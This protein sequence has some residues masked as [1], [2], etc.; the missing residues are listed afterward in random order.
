MRVYSNAILGTVFAGFLSCKAGGDFAGGG[1]KKEKEAAVVPQNKTEEFTIGPAG[2]GKVD[3]AFFLDTSDSM[4]EE[5]SA[6]LAGLQKFADDLA[7][8]DNGLDYQMFIVA[9]AAKISANLRDTAKLDLRNSEVN[10]HSALWNAY[11]FLEGNSD[12]V[13]S[14]S[15][16]LRMEAVKELVFLTDDDAEGITAENLAPYLKGNM[17]KFGQTRI[18]GFVGLPTSARSSTCKI[19]AVGKSY[20]ALGSDPA[21]G[22][23]VADVCNSNWEGL[24]SDLANQVR[25]RSGRNSEFYLKGKPSA[26]IAVRLDGVSFSE[27]TYDPI[28]NKVTLDSLKISA[29]SHKVEVSY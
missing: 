4:K 3:L 15:L 29:G 26:G 7:E 12:K 19:A 22:G 5:I 25:G 23:M 20:I 1:G 6:V 10:S 21:I 9:K 14:G 11:H 13:P 18:N 2:Q 27:F 17:A 28:K 8:G 24:L 16:K